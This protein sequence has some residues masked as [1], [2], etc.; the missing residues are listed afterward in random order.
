MD[1]PPREREIFNSALSCLNAAGIPFVV[2]G[3][4]CVHFYTGIWRFTKDMDV[5]AL[6]ES[7]PQ[8]LDPLA[9]AGF[10][11]WI[12]AE[13]WLGKATKEDCL[14]DVIFGS[15]N[16]LSPVDAVWLARSRPALLLGQ[17]V[18]MAPIEEMIWAKSYVAGRE[19]YDGADIC[20]LIM[21][22]EGQ[23][24]W[25]HLLRRYGDHWQLLLHYLNLYAFIYPVRQGDIPEWI[26]DE[27]IARLKRERSQPA[28]KRKVCRGTL[29][30]RFSYNYD[31]E[32]LGYV[33]ARERYARA[34]GATREDV[35]SERAWAREKLARG[36]VYKKGS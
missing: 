15:G 25:H 22:S 12:E 33:D 16:W 2:A 36:E 14:V 8:A 34:H 28:P 4:F 18:R 11:T 26:L 31:V 3:A 13:H 5:F 23:F 10:K 1:L 24:D 21:A 20:H 30:D 6:P 19:R 27:L 7:V 32:R 17:P 9:A 35:V 29:L